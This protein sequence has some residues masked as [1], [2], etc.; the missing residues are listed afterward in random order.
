M[1]K[2][3][4]LS[5]CECKFCAMEDLT[6]HQRQSF[7]TCVCFS[8]TDNNKRT[9][10]QTQW[11]K[12]IWLYQI[13]RIFGQLDSI[14]FNMPPD[15]YRD[16][17]SLFGED[18]ERYFLYRQRKVVAPKMADQ[19]NE[20]QHNNMTDGNASDTEKSYHALLNMTESLSLAH[21]EV[22]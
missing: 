4:I 10:C 15:C 12:D 5:K 19:V 3:S 16:H 7:E 17:G 2:E 13:H 20:T 18:F 21:M 1:E 8:C 11:T 22:E 14:F 6:P 9:T